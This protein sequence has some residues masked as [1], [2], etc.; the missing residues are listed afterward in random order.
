MDLSKAF[1]CPR[2]A[3]GIEK[4]SAYGFK[5]D[6]LKFFYSCLKGRKQSIDIKE[7]WGNF[8]EILDGVPKG[9]NTWPD[10]I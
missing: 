6:T 5:K 8:L 9:L 4:L 2:T 10:F 1:D 7:I 3:P